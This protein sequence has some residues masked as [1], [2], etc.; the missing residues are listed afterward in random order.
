MKRA[1]EAAEIDGWFTVSRAASLLGVPVPRIFDQIRDGKLQVR[2]E[3]GEPGSTDR[4]FVTS[5][6]LKQ[7]TG[8]TSAPTA[9]ATGTASSTVP[10]PAAVPSAA[11]V[12]ASQQLE[13]SRRAVS[14]LE[15]ELADARA[16]L[17]EA[18]ARIDASLKSIYERDVRIARLEAEL[19]GRSKAR[20]DA[21]SFIRH[22][23]S[24]LDKTEERS[25]E[26]EKEIRRLAVG[27]GEARGEIRMLKPPSPEPV[28]AWKRAFAR[29]ALALAVIAA[30]AT[31]GWLAF[32]FATRSMVL[33][34]AGAAAAAFLAA[35][36]TGCVVERL[37][38]T[39]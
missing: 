38:K 15:R 23:E 25:E 13:E 18:D 39:G 6:E 9:T 3:P 5:P 32:A 28:R 20:E 24:R 11:T 30:A 12:A 27:L 22:L 14:R 29:G 7:R 26:K 2:F 8:G 1:E 16:T 21:E 35:F 31:F 33:E 4:P 34:S 17:D 37:R 19:E 36:A 10:T